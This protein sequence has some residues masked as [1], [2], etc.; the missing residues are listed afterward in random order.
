[1]YPD[2]FEYVY[3]G[4]ATQE[5]EDC[6]AEHHPDCEYDQWYECAEC[7]SDRIMEYTYH[8]GRYCEM[9]DKEF[10]Q[11]D[12]AFEHDSSGKLMCFECF[13]NIF[14]KEESEKWRM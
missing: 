2:D 8:E 11:G 9:C 10:Q 5:C 6:F 12:N 13:D 7:G 1:M 4:L 3:D 14:G